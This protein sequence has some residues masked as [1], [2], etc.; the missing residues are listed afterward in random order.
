MESRHPAFRNFM[1]FSRTWLEASRSEDSHARTLWALGECAAATPVRHGRRWAASL[2][3]EAL[4]PRKRSLAAR[5]AFTLLGLDAYW[6]GAP[7]D[8]RAREVRPVLADRLMTILAAV[9]DAGMGVVRGGAC[10]R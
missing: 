3:A 1:G 9:E 10:L 5:M 2:F 7:D 6:R 4:R 8:L